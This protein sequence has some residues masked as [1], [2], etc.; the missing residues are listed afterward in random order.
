MKV[1]MGKAANALGV[2]PAT[3]RRWEKA[4]QIAAERPPTGRPGTT[5]PNG[6]GWC[7]PKLRH[8]EGRWPMPEY[9]AMAGRRSRYGKAPGANP[10]VLPPAGGPP[11]LCR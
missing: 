2:H 8:C 10:F 3:L 4:G 9:R 5:G 11:P 7:L 1:R 6:G